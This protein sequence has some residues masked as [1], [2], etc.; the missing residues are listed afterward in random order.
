MGLLT[1]LVMLPVKGP[2]DGTFWIASQ[3]AEQ[4]EKE[5]NS[6]AALR[7]ALAEAEQQLLAGT[8]SEEAYDAIEDDLLHRLL[9]MSQR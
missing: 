4:V 1:R 8:L 7:Q 6:P 9:K 3:L 5:R 2:L